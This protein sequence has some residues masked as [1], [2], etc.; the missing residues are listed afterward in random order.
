MQVH[1]AMLE[2][3]GKESEVKD[4]YLKITEKRL[5]NT[6][7]YWY[8]RSIRNTLLMMGALTT[9]FGKSKVP[10]PGGCKLGE[11]KYDLHIK[12]LEDT[13][14][15]YGNCAGCCRMGYQQDRSLLQNK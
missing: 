9:R 6:S 15:G 13:K 7:L 3:L 4:G 1:I 5:L 11:R 12:I 14:A 10:M 8:E 2:K